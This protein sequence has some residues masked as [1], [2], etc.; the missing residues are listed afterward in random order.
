MTGADRGY[1]RIIAAL[2]QG[3]RALARAR[4]TA[5]LLRFAGIALA[6]GASVLLWA[7]LQRSLRFYS[8]PVATAVSV[9]GAGVIVFALV[10][11][12]VVPL[13]RLPGRDRFVTLVE[14]KLPEEKNLVV[15][16]YQLGKDAGPGG[17]SPDLIDA[18]V[19]RAAERVD[20]LDLR[21]W[22]DPAPD[23]PYLWAG[24]AAVAVI[25]ALALLSPSLLTG[26]LGQVLR[27]STAK[28]PPVTLTVSPGAAEVERGEDLAITA[29]VEGT[30]KT[31]E[32]HFRERNGEWRVRPFAPGPAGPAGRDY[33][34]YR[35]VLKAVDR[36]L[37]YRVTAP[38]AASPLYTI[39]VK[40]PPR[41]TGFRAL[42]GYP[43]YSGLGSETVE[44][45]AGDVAALAG[46]DVDLRILTNRPMAG[47]FVEWL[48]EGEGAPDTVAVERLD[49][50]T[51]RLPFRMSEPATYS[52]ILTDAAGEE[53]VRSPRYRID[54]T[55]DRAPYLTLHL[56][57]S[58]HD[59]YD[60][61]M[62]KIVADAAD[63]YGFSSVRLYYRVDDE[64]E[65][66]TAFKP[67]TEGQNQF[68]LD[69]LW[70]MSGIEMLPGSVVSFYLKVL[71]N[72]TVNG[73]KAA[74]SEVRR[75][76]F[77]T[78]GEMYKEVA[79]EHRQEIGK[80]SDVHEEQAAL[81]EKL[82]KLADD[83]KAG[84]NMDWDARQ[85]LEQNLQQQQAMEK[86]VSEVLDRL[87][88]TLNKASNRAQ[89]NQQLVQKMSELNRLLEN[90]AGKEMQQ[91]LQRLS[92]AL[93]TMDKNRIRAAMEDLQKNREQMLQ[94]LD[95][96][97]ELLKQI[98]KEEQVADVVRRTEDIADL[99]E[100]IAEALKE[101]GEKDPAENARLPEDR[102]KTAP[103][104]EGARTGDEQQAKQDEASRKGEKQQAEQESEARKA[105]NGPKD[106]DEAS[107]K[108]EKQQD[109]RDEA[110]QKG[111]KQQN[112]RDGAS[113]EGDR[114]PSGDKKTSPEAMS[115][116]MKA[117]LQEIQDLQ[118][119]IAGEEAKQ[120]E[121]RAAQDK[122]ELAERLEKLQDQL[123]RLRQERDQ[124]KNQQAQKNPGQTP[125]D[126]PQDGQKQSASGQQQP[127][128]QQG[129]QQQGNR[130]QSPKSEKERLKRLAQKQ[131]QAK[132]LVEELK[133]RLETLKKLN[134]EDQD[135]S[136]NLDDMETGENTRKMQ[137][138]MQQSGKQMEGGKKQKASPYA[139]KARDQAR[140][141]A[142]QA[143]KMQK[144]MEDSLQDDSIARME[145]V[146]RGLIEI[147]GSE[148]RLF[149]S[150]ES[151][152][153]AL[154]SRQFNLVEVTRAYAESL[155]ALS[156]QTFAVRSEDSGQ[157]GKAL[158]TMER[159]T[160]FYELGNL[161][162]ARHEGSESSSELNTTIVKLM[163]SHQQ[164]CSGQSGGGSMQKML[165]QMQGLSQGQQ[166]INDQTGRMSSSRSRN[167]GRLSRSAKERMQWLAAQQEM[168]RQGLEEVQ[169][170]F[171]ES[172]DLLGDMQGLVEEMK[173]VEKKLGK[174]QIDRKLIQRQQ[175]ILTR[176]LDAQRSVRQQEMSPERESR[177]ATLAPRTS[178]PELPAELLRTDRTLE[179]DLL[180]GA[181]DRYPVQYRRLV[182]DYFRSLAKETRT[183]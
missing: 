173:D 124:E 128:Q 121:Q 37:E 50:T 34:D 41:I 151:D 130:G 152:E 81:Q 67:Y 142:Q 110:S 168:I 15:N 90:V 170:E 127:S 183:P 83:L 75:V 10:R 33:G 47:A 104:D 6:T 118:E 161:R 148:Q 153:R 76:R 105:E 59:L 84:K 48:R 181:N 40:E 109:T 92:E 46:T 140:Q 160:R 106:A 169:K 26:A 182:E 166:Q 43:A 60:D 137:E 93:K 2:D 24:G 141:L 98:R 132:Q 119:Q 64:P 136:R 17:G 22:R 117:L 21:R 131:K 32:L 167:Q 126:R 4:F 139:F 69:T 39:R 54:P 164:M 176:L 123:D 120:A 112:E 16:A 155:M 147:S 27:P 70:D 5:G 55:P 177:T 113:Q 163:Q 94:G 29:T 101:M 159:S 162:R 107:Q 102:E 74:T 77:P 89:M 99:Q 28:A 158:Q 58:D 154:A 178:P 114:Q 86:Q 49:E 149:Q 174:N 111:K 145:A 62:E 25:A 52:M 133:R 91:A 175:Q 156:R 143:Q 63:D 71:D 96:T 66:Y 138:N 11:W 31:P 1:R 100:Q 36:T 73:P 30:A 180:R 88:E 57:R 45:G 56:P 13:V 116:E 8:V 129:D 14:E 125:K 103:N 18:L 171:S 97:I 20:S 23:R 172:R 9:L 165:Q 82:Q 53:R 85:N 179:E 135:L 108:G 68:R 35:T 3:R 79:E 65:R 44:S 134:E 80:L 78:V 51:W 115:P 19:A 38:R 146:I 87:Q 95:R 72:D 12:L 42:L 157:L 150:G 144:Q 7:V 61:M 122:K